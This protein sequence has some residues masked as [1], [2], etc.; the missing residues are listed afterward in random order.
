MKLPFDGPPSARVLCAPRTHYENFLVN[1]L[2]AVRFPELRPGSTSLD[3]G[4][5]GAGHA[6]GQQNARADCVRERP[7]QEIR[8]RREA[9]AAARRISR[10][11]RDAREDGKP[12][13]QR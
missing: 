5:S 3:P 8:S 7:L 9:V 1:C 10:R 13:Y 2:V 4:E 12:G 6:C 11:D